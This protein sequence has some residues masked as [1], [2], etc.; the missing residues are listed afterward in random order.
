MPVVVEPFLGYTNC[1]SHA[2]NWYAGVE[3][4]WL[5]ENMPNAT[6]MFDT[7]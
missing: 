6:T 1:W 4:P 3:H 2:A 7:Q 5:E